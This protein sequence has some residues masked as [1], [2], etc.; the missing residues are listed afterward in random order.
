MFCERFSSVPQTPNHL[1][2]LNAMAHS[3]TEGLPADVAGPHPGRFRVGRAFYTEQ[4]IQ[5]ALAAMH[6][7]QIQEIKNRLTG[8]DW[9]D[10]VRIAMLM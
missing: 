5:Q 2:R 6:T 3:S 7:N 8:I 4:H 9:I 1:Y 10:R